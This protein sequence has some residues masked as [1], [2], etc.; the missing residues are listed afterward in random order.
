MFL[1]S[2]METALA[3]SEGN[4]TTNDDT[5]PVV[6]VAPVTAPMTSVPVANMLLGDDVAVIDAGALADQLDI[7]PL[8][9]GLPLNIVE[10]AGTITEWSAQVDTGSSITG[11]AVANLSAQLWYAP[12]L[13]GSPIS[14]DDL[15]WEPVGEPLDLGIVTDNGS[16]QSY[17]GTQSFSFPV[18]AGGYL[19][20]RFGIIAAVATDVVTVT[21]NTVSANIVIS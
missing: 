4:Q 13:T 5:P 2:K 17:L 21:A 11:G 14:L 1:S 15:A 9:L 19:L 8:T 10:A 3:A 7:S 20:V 12:P 6:T 16:N 18:V